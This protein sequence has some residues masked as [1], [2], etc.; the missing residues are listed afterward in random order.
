MNEKNL[1]LGLTWMDSGK[2]LVVPLAC[3][4]TSVVGLY[5]LLREPGRLGRVG[6]AGSVA[7]LALLIVGTAVQFWR[8]DWGS[9]ARD[10]EDASIG[11]VG[12][13]QSLATLMLAPALIPLGIACARRRVLPAWVVPVLPISAI[14]TFWLTPTNVLPGLAWLGLAGVL[15]WRTRADHRLPATS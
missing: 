3:F 8:F 13:L 6:V 10:F 11:A 4:L 15:W 1:V 5:R 7:A 14:A 9:Y 12:A 2:L